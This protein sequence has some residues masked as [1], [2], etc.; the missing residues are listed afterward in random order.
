MTGL[1][2]PAASS[3]TRRRNLGEPRR[4][5]VVALRRSSALV[6]GR[7][8]AAG[9][10]VEARHDELHQRRRGGEARLPEFEEG[11]AFVAEDRSTIAWVAPSAAAA[12][13]SR[14]P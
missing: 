7:R 13:H 12:A 14:A 2:D 10:V 4:R 5:D 9:F 11:H 6:V 1:F 8:T 3:R